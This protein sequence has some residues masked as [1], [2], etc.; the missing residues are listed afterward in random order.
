MRMQLQGTLA[1]IHRRF[2]LT[3]ILVSHNEDEIIRLSDTVFQ[4]EQGRFQQQAAPAEFFLQR[5]NA[6][7]LTGNVVSVEANGSVVILLD[8]RMLKVDVAG[9]AFK[10]D[11]RVVLDCNNGTPL[12]RKL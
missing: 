2:A 1:E 3:T 7:V 6:A 8:K 9:Q 10:I 12:I 4:L 11:D 5:D